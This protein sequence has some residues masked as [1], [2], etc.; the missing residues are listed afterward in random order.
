MK[1]RL[2]LLFPICFALVVVC[3]APESVDARAGS[4]VPARGR[5]S[6]APEQLRDADVAPFQRALL[7]LAFEAASKFPTFPHSKNRGRAQ[8]EVL[9]ACFELGLPK[10]AL[11]FAPDTEGWRRGLAYADYAYYCAKQGVT[12]NVDRYLE[13]AEAVASEESSDPNAQQWRIDKVRLKIARAHAAMGQLEKAE[14]IG[15]AIEA[16]S[17]SSAFSSRARRARGKV[18][19]MPLSPSDAVANNERSSVLINADDGPSTNASTVVMHASAMAAS[20]RRCCTIIL[21]GRGNEK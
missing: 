10:L 11:Q 3:C 2:H 1:P 5:V 9:V 16:T 8:E 4:Q 13:L 14:E 12:K 15:G 7:E 6:E 17:I 19:G 20:H 21:Q 18:D